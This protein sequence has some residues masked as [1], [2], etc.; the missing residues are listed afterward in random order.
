[1]LCCA[2]CILYNKSEEELAKL[3]ECPLDPGGYFIVRVSGRRRSAVS[4]HDKPVYGFLCVVVV[5]LFPALDQADD[6]V[7]SAA[8]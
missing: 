8:G 1:M 6:Y 5:V 2:R 3:G 4:D 7:Y